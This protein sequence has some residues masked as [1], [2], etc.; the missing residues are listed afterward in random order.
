MKHLVNDGL[1]AFF[2]FIVGLEVKSQFTIGELTDRARAAVPVIAAVAGLVVPALVF[3]LFNPS[4]EDALAWGMVISTDT[5]FLVGALAV[6]R[7]EV[8]RPAADVPAD[9]G[10]GRRRRRL[11]GDRTVLLRPRRRS[12]RC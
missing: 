4:G 2:F 6:I 5:A 11:A 1:M 8:P 7:P 12:C 9:A 3:L 10:R